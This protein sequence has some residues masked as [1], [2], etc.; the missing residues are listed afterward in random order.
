ML[1]QEEQDIQN[2]M[3]TPNNILI[4]KLLNKEEIDLGKVKSLLENGTL[5]PNALC[6]QIRHGN[7]II[8]TLLNI[9]CEAEHV[10]LV[11]LLI[12]NQTNPVNINLS[13]CMLTRPIFIA[14]DKQNVELARLLLNKSI[15]KVDLTCRRSEG[16][17]G[18]FTPLTLAVRKGDVAM[19]KVFIEA[20]VDIELMDLV[21]DFKIRYEGNIS[22]FCLDVC[23]SH[24]RLLQLVWTSI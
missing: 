14:V 11:E 10:Q 5:D 9:A 7:K 13:Y 20:G 18:Y 17:S 6:K 21:Q 3:L 15:K 1:A 2:K 12:T 24:I 22:F 16:V 19:V 8:T 4:Q 23:S